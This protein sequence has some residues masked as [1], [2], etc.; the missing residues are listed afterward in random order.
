MTKLRPGILFFVLLGLILAGCSSQIF[1]GSLSVSLVDLKPTDA[2]L[3]ESRGILTV[4][5][6]NESIAP[7]GYSGSSHKLY[8]NGQYVGKG[9]TDAPFG[10]PPLNSVTQDVPVQFENIALVRQLIE[11][12]NSQTIRYTL[13]SV[14]FQTI[15][16][17]KY[18]IKTRA[19]GSLDLHSLAGTTK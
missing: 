18:Q 12:R 10:V 14:L 3:L 7:L 11:V 6:T 13:E 1:T 5:Y 17:D 8:L 19:E 15:N 9:V 2:S 16:E 4:R